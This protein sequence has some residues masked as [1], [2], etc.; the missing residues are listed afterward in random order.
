MLHAY[1][2]SKEETPN[3][4]IAVYLGN[5]RD[6]PIGKDWELAGDKREAPF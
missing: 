3:S 5:W 2:H 1:T 4:M 6:Q